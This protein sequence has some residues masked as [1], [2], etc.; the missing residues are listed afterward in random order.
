MRQH[1]L[2]LKKLF[3]SRPEI[4]LPIIAAK[5]GW[6]SP[7]TAAMKLDG[8]RGW[9]TGELAKMCEIV[10]ITIIQLAEMSDDLIVTN[11]GE[12]VTAARLVDELPLTERLAALQ[13]L[14][15]IKKRTDD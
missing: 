11:T 6:K 4:T 14:M 15:S 9:K 7:R 3:D 1:R 10:G 13:Y 5:M 8:K 2:I 12:A